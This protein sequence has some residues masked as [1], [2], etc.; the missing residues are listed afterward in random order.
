MKSERREERTKER[1]REGEK[2]KGKRTV[3]TKEG[4]RIK[5]RNK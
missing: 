5:R 2:E 4:G 1:Q 3:R